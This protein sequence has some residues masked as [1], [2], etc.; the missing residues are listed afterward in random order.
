MQTKLRIRELRRDK[1]LT[2]QQLAD[3]IGIKRTTLCHYETGRCRVPVSLLPEIRDALG[4]TWEELF[5]DE[6]S[7]ADGG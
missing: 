2:Q 3:A 4:C 7:P 1:L 5:D 6:N